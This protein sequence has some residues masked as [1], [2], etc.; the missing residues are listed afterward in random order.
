VEEHN[1]RLEQI[2]EG[3]RHSKSMG[4]STSA[5]PN[6]CSRWFRTITYIMHS[7]FIFHT[8]RTM[9]MIGVGGY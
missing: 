5:A 8:L 7:H 9:R 4:P 2:E 3:L 1:E 6:R